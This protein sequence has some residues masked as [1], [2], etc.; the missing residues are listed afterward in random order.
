MTVDYNVP[1]AAT[2]F[3]SL[4]LSGGATL[5]INCRRIQS[6]L[7]RRCH[8]PITVGGATLNV[9]VGGVASSTNGGTVAINSGGYHE[10]E[11]TVELAPLAGYCTAGDAA[12]G[13]SMSMRAGRCTRPPAVS[14]QQALGCDCW[15]MVEQW[16]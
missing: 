3:G 14:P 11:R 16:L 8:A 5:N 15:S 9:N 6:R 12:G 10:C 13:R 2:S 7:G 4:N 1:M